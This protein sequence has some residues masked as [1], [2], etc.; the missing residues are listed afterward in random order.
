M[1]GLYASSRKI[2]FYAA[3][4]S[5]QSDGI[6]QYSAIALS[7]GRQTWYIT[8]FDQYEQRNLAFHTAA[9]LKYYTNL[10]NY[11]TLTQISC[12]TNRQS[13][14]VPCLTLTLFV[15]RVFTD[16]SDTA[17]SLYD[18]A[19]FADRLYGWSNLHSNSPFYRPTKLLKHYIKH[20]PLMQALFY[21]LCFMLFS[22]TGGVWYHCA[23]RKL[24]SVLLL[25]PNSR[26]TLFIAPNDSSLG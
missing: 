4:P 9:A 11:Q 10:I 2:K 17:F 1:T 15:F 23:R 8:I 22:G 12:P 19:F 5:R 7:A 3:F 26:L 25:S 6:K 14:R 16:N 21:L 13:K 20:L 24:N 18:L